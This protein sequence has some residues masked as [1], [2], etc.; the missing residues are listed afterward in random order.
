MKTA[1]I[2]IYGGPDRIRT[3]DPYNANKPLKLFPIISG[4]FWPFPLRFTSSLGLFDHAVSVWS[5]TVCG[6]F[7]GQKRSPAL[8][9]AFRRQGRGAFFMPLTACIV[10]L[11]A[12]LS[13]SFLRHPRFRNWGTVNK[14][15]AIAETQRGTIKMLNSKMTRIID[16]GRSAN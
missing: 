11:P 4:R 8:A 12:G 15:C 16:M 3:D 13:K 9:G 7:C 10:P 2:S 1:A 14:K 6:R 5:G